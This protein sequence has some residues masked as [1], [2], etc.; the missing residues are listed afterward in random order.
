MI[1]MRKQSGMTIP[2]MLIVGL[3]SLLLI[4][5][6]FAVVPM[7]GDDRML[8]TMLNKM[9]SSPA[10]KDSS[11]AKQLLKTIEERLSSNNLSIPTDNAIIRAEKA[12][13]TLDWHY[14]RRSNW[15]SNIDIVVR[16]HQQAEF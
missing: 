7:Y 1:N 16:F 13:L 8:T 3:I 12:G 5:A 2:S 6:A 11:S 9:Q 15:I 14:E 10:A 4:K